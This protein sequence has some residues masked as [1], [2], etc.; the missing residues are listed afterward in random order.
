MRRVA[1]RAVDEG[2]IELPAYIYS[3]RVR[4][5]FSDTQ[6]NIRHEYVGMMVERTKRLEEKRIMWMD[7]CRMKR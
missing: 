6:M 3:G 5:V 7:E 4:A 1:N 2:V